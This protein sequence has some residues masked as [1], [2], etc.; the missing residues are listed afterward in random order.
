MSSQQ[1]KVCITCKEDKPVDEFYVRT[2]ARGKYLQ[3]SCKPCKKNLHREWV[4]T[5]S[6]Q[7]RMTYL[8]M[9]GRCKRRGH[10][11]PTYTLEEFD[12][13]MMLSGY[14]S[15]YDSWVDSDYDTKLQPSVDRLDNSRG[16]D[17]DNI[18]LVTWDENNKA[19]KK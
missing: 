1:T 13:W 10:I 8:Q 9:K 7:I 17:L 19:K 15:L 16:Y 6:G 18:R 4:R 5:F 3:S 11:M 12:T 14:R 2:K